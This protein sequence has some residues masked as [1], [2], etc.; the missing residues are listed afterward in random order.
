MVIDNIWHESGSGVSRTYMILENTDKIIVLDTQDI[1]SN[2]NNSLL[3]QNIILEETNLEQS[4]QDDMNIYYYNILNEI[5][6]FSK[7]YTEVESKLCLNLNCFTRAFY[8][9]FRTFLKT[10]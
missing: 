4:T 3:T 8:Q 9:I 10:N 1:S 2:S 6:S 5:K 7:F